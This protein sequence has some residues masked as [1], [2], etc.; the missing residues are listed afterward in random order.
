MLSVRSNVVERRQTAGLESGLSTCTTH[1]HH[2]EMN[3]RVLTLSVFIQSCN[4][5]PYVNS[6]WPTLSG[7]YN[8]Y[9]QKLRSKQVT[10]PCTS[11]LLLVSQCKLVSGDH[12]F[13]STCFE[14]KL[15]CSIKNV[16]FSNRVAMIFTSQ[17]HFLSN[18]EPIS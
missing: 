17:S 9:Q 8:K 3:Y 18:E 10:M 15:Y 11:Q 14:K 16:L 5:P 7:T 2:T 4:Q 13:M 6:A 12:K 1:I